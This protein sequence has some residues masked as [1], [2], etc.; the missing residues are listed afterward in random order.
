MVGHVESFRSKLRLFTDCLQNN[1]LAHLSCCSVIR[2]G[3]S[4]ADF[5]QF[6]SNAASLSEAFHS[7][8]EDFHKLKSLLALY[9]NPMQ[10]NAA[11]QPSEI[12]LELCDLQNDQFLLSKK[13]E[14]P[15]NF[16]K[17][18]SKERFPMLKNAALKLFSMFGST[19]ICEYAFS[20]INIIKSKNRNQLGNN[21][22]ALQ[23]CL[24]M[25]TTK[26]SRKYKRNCKRSMQNS[27]FAL[28][29]NTFTNLYVVIFRIN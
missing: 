8:L 20:A 27:E 29:V 15:K 12:Q 3:Y 23:N 16:W 4:D 5:T 1:D 6:I 26:H 28:I 24:C 2:D 21:T 10:V 18:V 14:N 17:F 22:M 25:V 19:Y 11:T 13:M 9:N 7:R